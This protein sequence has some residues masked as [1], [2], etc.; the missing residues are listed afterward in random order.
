MRVAVYYENGGPEVF[1]FEE[2]AD[3]ICG[4]DDVLIKVEAASVEGG[5]LINREMRPLARVP[6]VAG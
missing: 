4:R 2:V 5:D 3:P 6:H 1:R